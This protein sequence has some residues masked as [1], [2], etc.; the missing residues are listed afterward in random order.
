MRCPEYYPVHRPCV[1]STGL[2]RL[3]NQILSLWRLV[4]LMNLIHRTRQA[5]EVSGS[6]S[7]LAS[8]LSSSI[9]RFNEASPLGTFQRQKVAQRPNELVSLDEKIT[10]PSFAMGPLSVRSQILTKPT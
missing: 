10:Q 3:V 8:V 2:S 1:A 4:W 6:F 5:R 9:L 7:F